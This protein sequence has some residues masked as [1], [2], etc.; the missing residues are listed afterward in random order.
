MDVVGQGKR[1][2]GV[3]TQEQRTG[4]PLHVRRVRP[5]RPFPLG[6]TW[7]GRGVNFALYSENATRVE[8]CLFDSAEALHE[9]VRLTLPEVTDQIWHVY[10]PDV[11]PGQIYGYRVYGPY[12]PA[13]GHR[14]NPHKLL[15][16]PYAKALAR[17]VRWNDTLFG[18]SVGDRTGDLSFD[19]RDSACHAPLAVVVDPAFSWGDDRPPRTAWHETVIYEV[20]VR[21]FTM[22]HPEIPESLRGTYAGMASEP[23]IR[24]LKA[25][26]VTAV[27]LLPVHAHLDD[28]HLT[29]R[30]T[31]NY[32]G[33]NTLAF[34]APETYYDSTAYR[35]DAVAEF[36]MWFAH[37]MKRASR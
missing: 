21:G 10:L 37:S 1:L 5:G 24:H 12:E 31:V 20:H 28:R 19:A 13:Q 26:G 3:R 7:D 6:A 18:Y 15:L 11:A 8:L 22:R 35:L 36:K 14:F 30:G 4:T 9:S 33:Y 29:E 17:R 25:L 32:W 27:E 2:G 16:D 23:A 34:F